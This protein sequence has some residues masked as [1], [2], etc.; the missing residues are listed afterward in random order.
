[1]LKVAFSSR[2]HLLCGFYILGRLA[3]STSQNHHLAVATPLRLGVGAGLTFQ[4][5]LSGHSSTCNRKRQHSTG[6]PS[7]ALKIWQWKSKSYPLML[8]IKSEG[9]K[10]GQSST[11][12]AGPVHL[13]FLIHDFRNK[14]LL[15]RE[16]SYPTCQWKMASPSW[17][18]LGV[19]A[20]S[21][22]LATIVRDGDEWCF[23]NTRARVRII[24]LALSF[25]GLH[26]C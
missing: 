23:V 21:I 24:S 22:N 17:P 8:F 15:E 25:K 16:E 6:R 20:D 3:D 5:L 10:N 9:E 7:C 13:S 14:L 11:A 19:Q 2:H 12:T 4:K 26:W 18:I 1:M